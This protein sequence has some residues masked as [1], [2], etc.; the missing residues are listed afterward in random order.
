MMSLALLFLY[1]EE[2]QRELED[3][4]E[5]TRGGIIIALDIQDDCAQDKDRIEKLLYED[6]VVIEDIKIKITDI[7]KLKEESERKMAMLRLKIT[8]SELK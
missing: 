8:I 4:L 1:F 3:T 5:A 7:T 6:K 2:C